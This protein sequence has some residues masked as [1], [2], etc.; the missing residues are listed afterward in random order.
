MVARQHRLT[1]VQLF[2]WRKAYLEDSL[3]AVGANET[4]LPAS[5]LQESMIRIKQLKVAL[6]RKTLENE[7]IKGKGHEDEK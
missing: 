2:K 1:A 4:V 6:G 7:I 5:E 3:V